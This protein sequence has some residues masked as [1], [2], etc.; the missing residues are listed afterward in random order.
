MK[1]TRREITPREATFLLVCFSVSLLSHAISLCPR[2]VLG[3]KID[4]LQTVIEGYLDGIV[5]FCTYNA[6]KSWLGRCLN[7]TS[8]HVNDLYSRYNSSF[9]VHVDNFACGLSLLP[10]SLPTAIL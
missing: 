9:I 10:L 7:I 4:K 2:L 8:I 5:A 3:D 6:D 1:Q